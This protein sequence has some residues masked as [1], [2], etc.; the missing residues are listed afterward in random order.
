MLEFLF[1]LCLATAGWV[2]FFRSLR[3]IRDLEQDKKQLIRDH[4]LNVD[5]EKT[6]SYYEG[7]ADRDKFHEYNAP[8]YPHNVQ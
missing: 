1:L 6:Q 3:T 7:W 2:C 8:A 5:K 4:I